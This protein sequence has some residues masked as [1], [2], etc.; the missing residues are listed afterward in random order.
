MSKLITALTTIVMSGTIRSAHNYGSRDRRFEYQQ[1]YF[2]FPLQSLMNIYCNTKN[3][4][5][6]KINGDMLL[7]IPDTLDS[8]LAQFS[9]RRWRCP[10]DI[11][12]VIGI[13]L[14]SDV[15]VLSN[16]NDLRRKTKK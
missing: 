10:I 2:L 8:G 12:L 5:L 4:L 1:R 15:N 14:Y 11:S 7:Y 3:E 13:W 6:N 16:K 9:N